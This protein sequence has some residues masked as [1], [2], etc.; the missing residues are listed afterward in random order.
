[1]KS[2]RI[3]MLLS[4]S[5]LLLTACEKDCPA[6]ESDKYQIAGLWIGTY[7]YKTQPPL[8]FSFTIYPDGSMMYKSKGINDYTFYAVGTWTLSKNTFSYNVTTTNNPGG[9]Q[10]NQAGTA[11]YSEEGTL[12]NGTNREVSTGETGTFTMNRVK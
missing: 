5:L 8:F 1:M 2:K 10:S 3:L 6:P 4:I 7:S 12:T 9:V 11:T